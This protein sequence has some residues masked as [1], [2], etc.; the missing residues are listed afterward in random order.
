ME[1]TK[2]SKST[3]GFGL[4]VAISS[5]FSGLL[6]ILKETN[7]PL[8]DWMMS[9]TGHHWVTHGVITILLFLILGFVVTKTNLNE[10]FNGNKMYHVIIWSS[11][12]GS[13]LVVGFL[14]SH[15]L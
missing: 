3:V 10:K 14:L 2:L 9:L 11:V 7:T 15:I 4:S 13:L 6:V 8:K 12:L 1:N 5:I